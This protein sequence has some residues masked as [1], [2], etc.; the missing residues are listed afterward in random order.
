M[1]AIAGTILCIASVVV[2]LCPWI[3][4]EIAELRW[5]R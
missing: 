3:A 2:L 5:R 4:E 1:S